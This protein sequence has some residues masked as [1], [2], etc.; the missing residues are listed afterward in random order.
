MR[1]RSRNVENKTKREEKRDS[2]LSCD[3]SCYLIR[4]RFPRKRGGN[5]SDRLSQKWRINTTLTMH[6]LKCARRVASPLHPRS[7]LRTI[8]VFGAGRLVRVTKNLAYPQISA[9]KNCSRWTSSGFKICQKIGGARRGC[10]SR[11][12]R[13]LMFKE[14]AHIYVLLG[15][16]NLVDP[17]PT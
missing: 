9:K 17:P 14:I 4:R 16:W 10:C 11:L 7:C 2:P 8:T 15:V 5:K 12:Q 3:A 13:S 1:E 6:R